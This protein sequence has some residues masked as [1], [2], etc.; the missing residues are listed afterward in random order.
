MWHD[1]ALPRCTYHRESRQVLRGIWKAHCAE[2]EGS[3]DIQHQ[4]LTRR[5]RERFEGHGRRLEFGRGWVC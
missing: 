1:G 3:V 4:K 2:K 5:L